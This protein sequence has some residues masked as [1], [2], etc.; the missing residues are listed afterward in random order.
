MVCQFIVHDKVAFLRLH[1][2]EL[3]EP[4]NWSLNSPDL[5]PVGYPIW[6]AVRDSLL[7]V[8][9]AFETLST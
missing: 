9:V 5:N 8:V 3:V 7:T 2:P 6:G 4:E 1:V